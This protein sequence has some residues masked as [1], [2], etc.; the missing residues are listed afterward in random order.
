MKKRRKKKTAIIVPVASMGDIAF[1]LIIFFMVASNLARDRRNIK[2]PR[3]VDAEKLKQTQ[4]T[5][6]VDILGKIYLQGRELSSASEVESGVRE[7]LA[8][9]TTKEQKTVI[10]KC[11]RKIKRDTFEPV[12]EAIAKAGGLLAAVGEKG[13]PVEE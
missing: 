10:F 13:E 8:N 11:D 3:S 6:S 2:P 5:V 12:I 4:V 7:L 1:L 9:R